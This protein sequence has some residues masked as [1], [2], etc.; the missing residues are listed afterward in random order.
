MKVKGINMHEIDEDTIQMIVYFHDGE[1]G[2]SGHKLNY[3]FDR[4][5][6]FTFDS[7]KSIY[8]IIVGGKHDYNIEVIEENDAVTYKLYYSDNTYWNFPN[9]FI[10]EIIDNGDELVFDGAE[11]LIDY[12]NAHE[13]H[14]LLAYIHKTAS[15]V[16][17][18]EIE[19]VTTREI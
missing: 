15:I 18:I 5:Q 8:R 9:D 10:T 3:L 6:T 7:I 11:I 4:S 13:L 1:S 14:I 19:T 12:Q 16:D 17:K 2:E